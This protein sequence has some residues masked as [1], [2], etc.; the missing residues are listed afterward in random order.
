MALGHSGLSGSNSA[1]VSKLISDDSPLFN[2]P[3]YGTVTGLFEAPGCTDFSIPQV[4]AGPFTLSGVGTGAATNW[5]VA[6]AGRV[7]FA[8]LETGTTSTGVFA[9]YT[10]PDTMILGNG[11]ARFRADINI[12]TASNGTDTFSVRVG[13]NDTANSAGD[14]VD[15]VFFRYTH[16]VNSGNWVCVTR[17][18]SVETAAN[19][20]I[21]GVAGAGIYTSLEIEVNADASSVDFRINGANV[22][23]VTTNIPTGA[24]RGTGVAAHIIKSLGTT[25]RTI[26]LDLIGFRVDR[27]VAV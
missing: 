18:N 26:V 10:Q 14:G 22:A 12:P 13:F 3:S 27:S 8:T 20:A 4:Y 11:T 17:S 25:N 24:G 16:S 15:G 6:S 23:T 5:W 7:G 2:F 1:L 21:A 19:T 9:V